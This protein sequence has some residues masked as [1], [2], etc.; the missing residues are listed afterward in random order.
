MNRLIYNIILRFLGILPGV[1][2]V[3]FASAQKPVDIIQIDQCDELSLS[4]QEY[5][6]DRY[7]WD[8]YSE[9]VSNFALEDS[10]L[11]PQIYFLGGINTG[12]AVTIDQKLP[13]GRYFIRIMAWAEANNNCTNNLLIFILDIKERLPV[14]EI[15]ESNEFCQGDEHHEIRIN[16]VGHG[17][18]NMVYSWDPEGKEILTLEGNVDPVYYL[19]IPFKSPGNHSLWIMQV[20]DGCSV[21]TY[22]VPQEVEIKIHP[23]PKTSGIYLKP[24]DD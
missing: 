3:A 2:T 23:R 7:V 14:A 8:I 9:P 17:P 5:P 19:P 15:D 10:D 16:V 21:N 13:A 1:L 12:P 11:D 20:S 4:I 6:G 22:E 24:N 18:W